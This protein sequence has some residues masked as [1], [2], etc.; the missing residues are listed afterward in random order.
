MIAYLKGKIIYKNELYIIVEVANIGYKVFVN[1]LFSSKF[2]VGDE[3]EVYTY[4]HV[5]EDALDLY[6]FADLAELSMFEL[7]LSIS[8]IGPKSAL[9][10]L[11]VA[12]VDEIRQSIAS[13]DISLLTKVSGI[14]KKTAERVVL[15][16]KDKIIKT[17]GLG[18]LSN[19]RQAQSFDAFADEMDALIALGYSS[20]QARD[21][22]SKVD[23][24][25]K[26]SGQRIKMA[27][28]NIQ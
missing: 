18:V 1:E 27:L 8:G 14:G 13:G 22:L 17:A 15:E 20:Q 4:Q 10:V 5:K 9:S 25:I 12:V 23:K 26:D 2:S 3:L 7:L 11:E 16:L 21:A 24:N 6:G 19:S 28:K